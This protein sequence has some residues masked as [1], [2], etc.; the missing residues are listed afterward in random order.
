MKREV[1]F[2]QQNQK[3]RSP[4]KKMQMLVA[5]AILLAAGR[6]AL[7]RHVTH[8]VTPRNIEEQ[9]YAFAVKATDAVQ[10]KEFEIKVKQKL[11]E[12]PPGAS[13]RGTLAIGQIGKK[14]VAVP[15][16]TMIR[17]GGEIT[18]TFVIS[19]DYLDRASFTFTETPDDPRQPFP[20]PGDYYVFALA[21]FVSSPDQAPKPHDRLA[22][23][24]QKIAAVRTKMPP[25][26]GLGEV[27]GHVVKELAPYTTSHLSGVARRLGAKSRADCLVLLTY[28]NDP[29]VRLRF[30][31]VTAIYEVVDGYRNGVDSAVDNILNTQSNG[32]LKMVQKLVELVNSLKS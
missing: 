31:A 22:T 6:D 14:G 8:P 20:F 11:R 15:P 30:I 12:L 25:P 28:V 19:P 17:S 2:T 29:D 3:A 23:F 4:M 1:L 18:F 27:N 26:E 5:V 24:I 32:H 7:A 9:P 21:D 16:V 10:D 13:A